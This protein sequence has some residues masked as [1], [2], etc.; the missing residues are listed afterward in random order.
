MHS[1]EKVNLHL[2]SCDK[3]HPRVYGDGALFKV[4]PSSACV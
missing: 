3:G 1:K 4:R 2:E